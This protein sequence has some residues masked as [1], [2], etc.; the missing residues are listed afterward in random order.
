MESLQAAS[1]HM[2][3]VR[4][5][6]SCGE[7][8]QSPTRPLGSAAAST[9]SSSFP[10]AA[11]N[12]PVPEASPRSLARRPVRTKLMYSWGSTTVAVLAYT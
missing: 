3:A 10:V 11:S 8:R 1:H 2:H 4:C 7:G 12:H 6:S 9:A 5:P